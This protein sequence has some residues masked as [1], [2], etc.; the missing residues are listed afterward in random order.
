[1]VIAIAPDVPPSSPRC[2]A[3]L[4]IWVFALLSI[5]EMWVNCLTPVQFDKNEKITAVYDDVKAMTNECFDSHK[6]HDMCCC[7]MYG[8]VVAFEKGRETFY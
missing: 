4:M 5:F 2:T 1:M 3:S 6:L 8:I 7:C